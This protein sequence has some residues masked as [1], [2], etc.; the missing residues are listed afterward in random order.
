MG[1][2]KK[3]NAA[4]ETPGQT[5]SKKAGDLDR[6]FKDKVRVLAETEAGEPPSSPRAS[7]PNSPAS[8]EIST[9]KGNILLQELI[10]NLPSKEDIASMLARLEA[11][12]QEKL[13][14]ITNEVRQ[15]GLRV[16]D[17]EGDRDNIQLRIQNLEQRQ[18]AQD[19]KI[20]QIIRHTEDLDN[21]GRRNNLHLRGIPEH[22]ITV[23]RL[24]AGFNP[25]TQMDS[26][27]RRRRGG[28]Q[29]R[30]SLLRHHPDPGLLQKTLE[31]APRSPDS[32]T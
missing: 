26:P 30:D 22:H 19:G 4:Q 5:S 13:S 2:K 14:S 15:I 29:E 21:R 28:H 3:P 10:Q 16:G 12:M 1:N 18:D 6:Y 9:S 17:L 20:V 7:P 31:G 24:R 11:S 32:R 23:P 8:S 27:S 25:K